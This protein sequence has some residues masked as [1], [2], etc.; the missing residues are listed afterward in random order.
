MYI[1]ILELQ[2]FFNSKRSTGYNY[3]VHYRMCTEAEAKNSGAN[4]EE[5]KQVMQLTDRLYLQLK[6]L[7]S[8]SQEICH[9][10]EKS[11]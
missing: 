6:N 11:V 5:I 7:L 1:Y 10:S 4:K 9:R 8:I 2:V 3:S